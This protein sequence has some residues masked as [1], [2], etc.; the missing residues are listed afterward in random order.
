MSTLTS[1]D[2]VVLWDMLSMDYR[3]LIVS[4]DDGP[5]WE[6]VGTLLD[7]AGVLD[8][9]T[10]MT[11]FATTIGETIALPDISEWSPWDSILLAVHEHT[12]VIWYRAGKLQY[13]A[14]YL[15]S[16]TRALEEARAYGTELEMIYAK[17]GKVTRKHVQSILGRLES[18]A[19]EE[20]DLKA[21]DRYLT[22]IARGLRNGTVQ[23]SH[24]VNNAIGVLD[25]LRP[26]WSV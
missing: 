16:G 24:V 9:E 20:A 25:N 18:Y 11:R 12:H 2:A 17:T 7:K 5:E 22:S 4:K 26:G 14:N 19:L 15:R 10:F 13:L 3:T 1:R 8:R 6:A 21:A 23:W